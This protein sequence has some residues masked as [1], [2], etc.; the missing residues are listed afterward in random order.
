VATAANA[1]TTSASDV[2]SQRVASARRPSASTSDTSERGIRFA[3]DPGDGHICALGRI[4][5][6]HR[7]PDAG[8]AAGDEGRPAWQSHGGSF[9]SLAS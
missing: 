6:R 9:S 3:V 4:G 5:Q 2:T 7:A 8:V 1:A